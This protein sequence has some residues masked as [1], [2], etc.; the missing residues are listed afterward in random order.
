[1]HSKRILVVLG[2]CIVAT[3][4][5]VAGGGLRADPQGAEAAFLSE[6]KKLLASDPESDDTFGGRV[7]VS[8]DTAV[9]GAHG[10]GAGG[11]D[12]GRAYIFE[13]DEGGADNWGEVR[14]L[15]TSDPGDRFGISVAISGNTILV[16]ASADDAY[17]ERSGAAYIFE[18]DEGGADNWGEVQRLTASNAEPLDIFGWSVALDGDI[19]VV[20]AY[21]PV[22]AGHLDGPFGNAADAAAYVY[23]RDAGGAGNW[24]EV[25]KL[26][27]SDTFAVEFAHSVT[28]SGD[29]MLIGVVLDSENDWAGAAYVFQRDVG[30]VGNWGEVKKI[31]ASDG[32]WGDRFGGTV[33]LSGDT[34]VVG[35]HLE[36]S[37]CCGSGAAYVFE[38]NEG[39]ADN[40]GEVQRLVSADIAANDDFG[41]SVAASGDT[42][43]VGAHG[44]SSPVYRAGAAYLFERNAGG[45]DNW[46][47]VE[48][49]THSDAQEWDSFGWSVALSGSTALAST[50]DLQK[51]DDDGPS[52]VYVFGPKG[53][54]DTDQDGCSDLA[55]SGADP[56][57]GGQRDDQ[58]FWDFYDVWTHPP[59]DP[60]AW[61][62]NQVLN[63]FD[64]LAVAMRFG[65]G[66]P[67]DEQAAL[68]PP[69]DNTSYHP[70][71]DR[72][73]VIGA[74]NWNRG[75]ADG[76]INIVDDI[77]GI[78]QQFGH[79]CS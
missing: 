39:G 5:L 64:I 73:P 13:R 2:I 19:A 8:G 65:S 47:E 45:V 57:L 30:G 6:V 12:I 48:K 11:P 14:Q 66:A 75:P 77:L 38:R 44:P 16:G 43:I 26:T 32:Q 58:Y 69:V 33:S 23:E 34:A 74:N 49:L 28:V 76:S 46:G 71:Y 42:I 21:S 15:A 20:G 72:G 18:R 41:R 52:A 7:A 40:W 37:V 3:I 36:D 17:G 9:V 56:R 55:E 78:A 24:G 4:A 51:G 1:M 31:F 22:W 62:R 29:T 63:I 70:A 67:G 50:L 79:D 59:G 25:K 10:G 27:P 61:E 54:G 60:S 35:A 53:T 68:T